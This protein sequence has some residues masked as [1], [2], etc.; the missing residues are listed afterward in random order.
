MQ[1]RSVFLFAMAAGLLIASS[2]RAVD[3]QW[4]S[5]NCATMDGNFYWCKPDDK[6]DTQKTEEALRPVK[7]VYHKSGAN[8]II[9]FNYDD[10]SSASNAADY[11]STVRARY[12]SR[13]IK[14]DAVLKE[15]VNG[16]DVYI[17]S[18]VDPA[19]NFRFSDAL[20]WRPGLKRILQVEYTADA[21]D[22]ST[23]QPQ[24]MATVTSTRDLR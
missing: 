7:L 22:F 14:V 23:Y 13:G 9:W 20:F 5:K 3:L 12:E 21:G 11:A 1:K 17:V 16:K 4:S 8:P 6:W 24:F 10:L 19:K 18:G 15:N 2:A